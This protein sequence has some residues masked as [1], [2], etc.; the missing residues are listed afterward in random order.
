MIFTFEDAKTQHKHSQKLAFEL[1]FILPW[2]KDNKLNPVID[3]GCGTGYYISELFKKGY[4]IY[5][6]EGTE[7]IEQIAFYKPI[8]Q[9]DI[10]KHVNLGVKGSVICLEVIEHIPKEKEKQVLEN[11]HNHCNGKLIISWAVKGQ[12]GH[13][14]VN[15]QDEDYVIPTIEKMG[16]KFKKTATENIRRAAGKDLWWFKKSIYVFDKILK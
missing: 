11:L 16:Y 2:V 8:L 13:G 15:E 6:I 12:G 9:Y 3:F 5:G 7:G 14:H 1:R 4:K 10:S